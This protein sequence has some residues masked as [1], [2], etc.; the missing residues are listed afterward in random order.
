MDNFKPSS[1]RKAPL[2]PV[3]PPEI[4]QV[5]SPNPEEPTRMKYFKRELLGKP[6]IGNVNRVE[7]VGLGNLKVETAHGYTDV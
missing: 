2:P 3:S 4:V 7:S 5:E 6:S 1:R